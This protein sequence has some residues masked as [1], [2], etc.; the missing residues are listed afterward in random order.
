MTA[1]CACRKVCYTPISNEDGTCIEQWMCL[2]CKSI[3][4]RKVGNVAQPNACPQLCEG[5]RDATKEFPE[6][7]NGV[8]PDVLIREEFDDPE[9]GT[10]YRYCIGIYLK[11]G[12]WIERINGK[13]Y[14][15]YDVK[16]WMPIIPPA[17]V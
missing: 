4:V 3:F 7:I 8:C 13:E 1:K 9:L 15:L 10:M 5:W 2:D 6:M 17:F 14:I 12:K 11:D 16:Y